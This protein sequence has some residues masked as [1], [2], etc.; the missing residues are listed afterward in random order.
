MV[1]KIANKDLRYG[2]NGVR[3]WNGV[4]VIRKAG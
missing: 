4:P 1:I 3:S 2:P